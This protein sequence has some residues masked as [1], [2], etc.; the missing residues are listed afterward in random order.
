MNA[1]PRPTTARPLRALEHLRAA[2]LMCC[3]AFLST[4]PEHWRPTAVGAAVRRRPATRHQ[5]SVHRPSAGPL[6]ALEGSKPLANRWVVGVWP[7][8]ARQQ[9]GTHVAAETPPP[10]AVALRVG[11]TSA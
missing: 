7:C 2:Q 5:P 10:R 9:V 1:G 4:G 3:V 6:C 8:K 11:L